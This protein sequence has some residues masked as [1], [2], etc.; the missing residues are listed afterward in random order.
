MTRIEN[1]ENKCHKNISP[2]LNPL[3]LGALLTFKFGLFI[4]HSFTAPKTAKLC[5]E[6]GRI[7]PYLKSEPHFLFPESNWDVIALVSKIIFRFPTNNLVCSRTSCRTAPWSIHRV[8]PDQELIRES[9]VVPPAP[10]IPSEGKWDGILLLLLPLAQDCLRQV[11]QTLWRPVKSQ[12]FFTTRR[13]QSTWATARI[14]S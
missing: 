8:L 4:L 12:M 7:F 2:L 14:W 3:L 5:A 10:S 13:V 11:F 1:Q 9:Q 6:T